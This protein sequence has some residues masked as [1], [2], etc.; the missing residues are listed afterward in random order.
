MPAEAAA[1]MGRA[2]AVARIDR[3]AG[4]LVLGIPPAMLHG[5][6]VAEALIALIGLG[7]LARCA[8]A[9]EWRWLREGW[10]PVAGLWW[11]WLVLCSVPGIGAGGAHSLVQALA[12]VRF[13]LL[14]VALERQVLADPAVR[15][16]LWAVLAACA[17]WIGLQALQ[18][19]VVGRNWLGYP[20]WGDGELTGP[21]QKPRAAAP[22]ARMLPVVV[23]PP[24]AAILAGGREVWRPLAAAGLAGLAV[25]VMVL[26]GQRMP[27][28]LTVLGLL[29]AA[30]L[31]PRL[32]LPVAGALLA[33]AVLLAASAVVAPPTFYR[34]VTKFSTQMANWPASN[35]GQIASRAVAIAED[36]PL[37]G[38][39]FNGFR[40][41]C[42][43]TR[44]WRGW[45]HATNP[46]DDGGGALGCNIHPHNVYL[47]AVTDAGLPGLALYVAMVAAWCVA[48]ARGLWRDP[49]PL[50]VALF[51]SFVM[52]WWPLASNSSAFAVELGGLSFLLLGFG[53]A[54]ARAAAGPRR[55]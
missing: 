7:W 30:L 53:L 20:R 44:Y 6:A 28:L 11:A 38:R 42:G 2:D 46:A 36:H 49:A 41:G 17:A 13:L 8:L 47:Q 33:G 21:F 9:G 39:G 10:V 19:A 54:E 45:T 55:G 50:R 29:I 12:V 26:I 22:L 14:A 27:V 32:R 24:V 15:Q 23:V 25:A 52:A 35:Y 40:T 37:T 48:L 16:W 4:W 31:L 18:Q 1:L 3:A 5:F 43:D 34:L 51:A